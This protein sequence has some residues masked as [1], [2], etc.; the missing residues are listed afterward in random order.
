M[1]KAL[2]LIFILFALL[3]GWKTFSSEETSVKQEPFIAVSNFPLYEVS[4]KL[5]G[6][7][8]EVK[9][10]IPFGVEAHSYRPSVKT[11]TLINNAELFLFS[12]LGME[13]WIRDDYANGI[14]MSQF[15]EI[16]AIKD[17]H[18]HSH[19]TGTN[20]PHYWLKI[21][22]MIRLTSILSEKFERR[23]PAYKTSI[24][25]NA[26]NYINSLRALELEFNANF[27]T[28]KLREI[29]VNHNAFGYLGERY[30]FHIH[31][32]TGLSSDEQASA[33]KMKEI[34]DFVKEEDIKVIFFES[35][36]SDKVA[37]TLAKETGAQAQALQPLAN[38]TEEEAKKGYVILMRE[39]LKKLSKAMLC[40]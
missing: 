37:L 36:V 38:V 22:N 7:N 34:A 10:L 29:V 12:G 30:D 13:T 25:D 35:F 32:V 39:N 14:D 28:C 17:S 5:L 9:K 15:A 18:S 8:V 31:S 11:M 19:G 20:D 26:N 4:T 16:N 6:S 21:E 2:I 1:K 27:K 23:F 33:K 24:Q 3:L 40:Q